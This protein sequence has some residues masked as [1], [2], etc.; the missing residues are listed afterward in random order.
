MK[1]KKDKSG[2]KLLLLCVFILFIYLAVFGFDFSRAYE[3]TIAQ[4][5]DIFGQLFR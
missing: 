1:F 2:S 5:R 4:N 3:F